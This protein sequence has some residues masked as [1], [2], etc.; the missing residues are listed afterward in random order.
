MLLTNIAALRAST[1]SV[2]TYEVEGYTTPGDCGGGTFVYVASD[3]TSPDDGGEI[4]INVS[5]S[6][7]YRQWSGEFDWRWC[8][9]VGD[10]TGSYP[11][12]VFTGTDNAPAWNSL[13]YIARKAS[14]A[15][16]GFALYIPPGQFNFNQDN[17]G[18]QY[19]LGIKNL[20]V[21]GA[22]RGATILQNTYS[23]S[24]GNKQRP[25]SPSAVTLYNFSGMT[26][27]GVPNG[28]PLS[29]LIDSTAVGDTS[30]TLQT[31][32]NANAWAAGDPILI[33]SFDLM[34][35]ESYPPNPGYH[36]YHMVTGVNATTGV[37]TLDALV[38]NIHLSTWPDWNVPT[39]DFPIGKARAWKLSQPQVVANPL[40]YPASYTINV[41]FDVVHVFEDLTIAVPPL[42]AT[43][44]MSIAGG[45][46]VYHRCALPGASPSVATTVILDDVVLL[47]QSEP[48][49]IVTNLILRDV[50]SQNGFSFQ[51]SS[52]DYVTVDG[53]H[54]RQF[55]GGPKY[56]TIN[57][58]SF[59]SFF[60]A[61]LMVSNAPPSSMA[62]TFGNIF[63]HIARFPGASHARSM[64]RTSPMRMA[65]S[66]S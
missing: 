57:N 49:K 1:G 37:V 63:T 55:G 13:S 51:S 27:F 35:G 39:P 10:G 58:P 34:P 18:Y 64:K 48:D 41:A 25:I 16:N 14:Q 3:T 4:F 30:V 59:D 15:G 26:L 46:I 29:W 8:G 56:L 32:G 54:F 44:G 12:N 31:A 43:Y 7:Y 47:V 9:A 11:T 62:E 65:S 28:Q 5:G 36:E 6:R 19:L 22:G 45:H 20:R 52:I 60:L 42:P 38:Q 33:T 23:G 21:R 50:V 40:A 53:G 2:A 17:C 61:H 24:D 66:R